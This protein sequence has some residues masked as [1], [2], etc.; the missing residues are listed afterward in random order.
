[1]DSHTSGRKRTHL[2]VQQALLNM[3]LIYNTKSVSVTLIL[4]VRAQLLWAKLV[5]SAVNRKR[6]AADKK[7]FCVKEEPL[8]QLR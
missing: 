8:A 6:E 2:A 5:S 1:M 7:V 4:H 3:A